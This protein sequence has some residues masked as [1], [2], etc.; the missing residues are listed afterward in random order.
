MHAIFKSIKIYFPIK[1]DQDCMYYTHFLT[2]KKY[3]NK[4]YVC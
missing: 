3:K 1:M 4:N 2:L